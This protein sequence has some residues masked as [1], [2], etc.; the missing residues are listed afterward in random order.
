MYCPMRKHIVFYLVLIKETVK[1]SQY[2]L[3][4]KLDQYSFDAYPRDGLSERISRQ[5]GKTYFKAMLCLSKH[6]TMSRGGI[7]RVDT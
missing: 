7:C 6:C 1:L 2:L 3:S 4:V 5:I